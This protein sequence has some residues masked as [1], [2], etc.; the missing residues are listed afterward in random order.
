MN[1]T[2][3]FSKLNKLKTQKK[4]AKS[5]LLKKGYRA[6]E[7]EKVAELFRTAKNE[8]EFEAQLES[9]ISNVTDEEHDW[10]DSLKFTEKYVFNKDD[11]KYIFY[12]KA[13]NDFVVIPGTTIRGIFDNYSN[14]YKSPSSVNEI[15]R[16]YRIPK[17]YFFELR[18]ILGLTHD[19]EPI[20]KEELTSKNVDQLTED[21]LEKKKFQL[22]QK[23]QK[24]SW[25]DTEQA[26]AR[27]YE[28]I[29]GVFNPL[30]D[31]LNA[32][33]PPKYTPVKQI[34]NRKKLTDKSIIIGLSDIH[35]GTYANPEGSFRNKGS[36][37]EEIIKS[38]EKYAEDISAVVG[39]RTYGFDECVITSLGDIL[40]TTG[41]G[42]TTKGTVLSHDCIKEEQFNAA[43]DTLTKFVERMLEIFPKVKVKSVKGN[44]NDFGDYVLFRA[45]EAYFRK[46]K[47]ISFEVFQSEH[48]LFK[49]KNTLFVISHGYSAECK[50]HLP[51]TGKA[52][53]S[54]IANLFLANPEA[55]MDVKTK[56]LLTADQHHWEAKEYAEFEHYMLSTIVEGDKYAESMG[57][58]S[59]AKQSCFVIDD[60]GVAEIIYSYPKK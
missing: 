6:T 41:Q 36:N 27:W 38:I 7:A 60:E 59:R 9:L 47:R 4:G 58:N 8:R 33:T 19:S 55:L 54:Y 45:L 40:H 26:A 43:F 44:H 1:T 51:A 25:K 30:D 23:L 49:V 20:T 42:T 15:C 34:N 32:W 17:T 39:G 57:L 46:E 14:W 2:E 35:F 37:T 56:V 22:Y 13:A 52:R 31:L 21:I 28:F 16:N 48:G 11:D 53:E 10:S 29:E 24:K 18:E 12:L 3:L 50:G 5:Y